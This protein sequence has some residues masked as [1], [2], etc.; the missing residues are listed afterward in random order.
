[1]TNIH[2]IGNFEG[3]WPITTTE[4]ARGDRACP[5]PWGLRI[6]KTA[7]SEPQQMG[8]V[9]TEQNLRGEWPHKVHQM[10]VG[11][12]TEGQQ[13]CTW[14]GRLFRC[15][16]HLAAQISINCI[17]QPTNFLPVHHFSIHLDQL[18]QHAD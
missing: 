1:M 5:K 14:A 18:S 6:P 10:H 2:C 17:T 9:K 11:V 13:C 4:G 16:K 3:I 15:G 8:E 12:G 7:L